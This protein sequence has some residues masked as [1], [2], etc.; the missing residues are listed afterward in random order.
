M[1]ISDDAIEN[2]VTSPVRTHAVIGTRDLNGGAPGILNMAILP[3]RMPAHF[4]NIGEESTFHGTPVPRSH[5]K[6]ATADTNQPGLRTGSSDAG[7]TLTPIPRFN[8]PL[9]AVPMA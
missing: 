1:C 6:K 4:H 2:S 7:E 3:Q 5:K 8:V 9:D